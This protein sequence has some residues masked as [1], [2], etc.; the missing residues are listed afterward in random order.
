MECYSDSNSNNFQISRI[1][2]FFIFK[3]SLISESFFISKNMFEITV[4]STIHLKRIYKP[5]TVIWHL[6]WRWSQIEKQTKTPSRSTKF[7][8]L[9]TLRSIHTNLRI[10]C[11]QNIRYYEISNRSTNGWWKLQM[12]TSRHPTEFSA[13]RIFTKSNFMQ[14]DLMNNSFG[15]FLKP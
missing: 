3:S 2:S 8:F 12:S 9:L 5:K 7:W 10:F 11:R 14:L 1:S 15:K 13:C 6:F 4:L